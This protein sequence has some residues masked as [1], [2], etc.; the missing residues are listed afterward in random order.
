[1]TDTARTSQP[2]SRRSR[3]RTR[4]LGVGGAVL[5][6]G[7]VWLVARLLDIEL[8]VDPSNGDPMEVNLGLVIGFT[9][10]VSLLGWAALALLER[11]TGRARTIWTVLAVVVLLLSFAAPLSANAETSTKVMLSL[12][13]VAVGAVLI[14]ALRR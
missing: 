9:L 10:A 2:A 14:P 1:M 5:A 7:L 3:A 4:A 11:L 6:T 12:M 8:R 13:H